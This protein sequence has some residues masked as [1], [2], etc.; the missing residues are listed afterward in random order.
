MQVAFRAKEGNQKRWEIFINEEKWREVHRAIF[1]RKPAF[2]PLESLEELPVIFDAFEYR[3]V[4]GYVLWRLSTQS[5]HSEQLAK[6]LK[7]RLVQNQTITRVLQEYMDIGFLNDE[8]WLQTFMRSH[9]KRYSLRLILSKLHAKGLSSETVQEVAKN[10]KD[11]EVEFHALQHLLQTRY[12]NKDF[13]QREI[14]QKVIAALAR[15]GYSFSQI[16]EAFQNLN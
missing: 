12:R 14:K 5:Y 10:W 6:L 4:K 13:S 11:P 16:Q 1:G 15:K 2:P 9:Q 8:M 3:R 7:E